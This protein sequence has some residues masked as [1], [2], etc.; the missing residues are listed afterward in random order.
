MT[1]ADF[2]RSTT[3]EGFAAPV[4]VERDAT[5]AL[6]VHQHPFHARALI[7]EGEITLVVAGVSRTYRPGDSFDLP[8]NTPHEEQAGPQGVVY[9]SARKERA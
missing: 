3:A 6:G 2:E 9:F 5:Y 4:R 8:E 1:L 7:T